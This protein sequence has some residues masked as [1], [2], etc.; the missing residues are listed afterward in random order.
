MFHPYDNE[1]WGWDNG[2]WKRHANGE[3]WDE[4][5]FWA[6][7][8]RAQVWVREKPLERCTSCRTPYIAV[9][10]DILGG[11]RKSL[12]LSLWF[13]NCVASRQIEHW[14]WYLAVQDG[15]TTA[16]VES[17]IDRFAGIFLGG[18]DKFKQSACDW[19]DM[20]HSHGKRFHYA[21]AST[22]RKVRYA[23]HANADSLDSAFPLWTNERFDT[24]IH[25]MDNT[26]PQTDML[27]A[28]ANGG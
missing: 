5:A 10:P 4:H 18:T 12:D 19:S 22:L 15:M 6:S 9:A 11:G 3:P 1:P 21:R 20:A 7:L 25:W 8:M 2:A 27:S 16:D 26:D 23:R 24:F 28:N 14:P 13:I 17:R